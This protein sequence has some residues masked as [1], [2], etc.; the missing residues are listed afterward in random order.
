MTLPGSSR[1]A[2]QWSQPRANSAPIPLA[3]GTM[4]FGK[5]TNAAEAERIIHRA[6]E[7][8]IT[9]FDTA[10]VYC[11]GESERILGRALRNR[12]TGVSIATK[13]GFGR[14]S[15][16]LEGL[17]PER[18]RA[19]LDESLARLGT[20]GVDLY[21]LHVP[22]PTTPVEASLEALGS[23]LESKKIGSF[24]ISNY[25]SWQALE[26]LLAC[27]AA[28]M[29]R[30]VISQQLYNMMIRQ[31][32][33][34]Y[35]RFARKYSLHTTI[36]NPLAGGLLSG[37][38]T[39][40]DKIEKGSRFDQN[41]LYQGRY[42]SP[43]MISFTG[44]LARV[45]ES[46]NMSLVDFAYAWLASRSEVDSILIGPGSIDHLDQAIDAVSKLISPE[47]TKRVDALYKDFQGTD[48]SYAR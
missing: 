37:R 28:K 32:D 12:G 23:L 46:E 43:A 6:L 20:D 2:N 11:D 38:Y 14:V 33:L 17:A 3:L 10:N 24:G 15:G 48:A 44:E 45:A 5:R 1:L 19:A 34:E 30:P 9:L 27:D 22:D 13:V 39:S 26:I 25:A 35:F 8:G 31:L 16:K 4:N 29:P 7:R 41:R 36:Y 40:A 47:A 18:V 21:Y 42:W